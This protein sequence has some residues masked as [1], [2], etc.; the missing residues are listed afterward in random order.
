MNPVVT[1]K[2]HFGVY[3]IILKNNAILLVRKS[4]GPYTGKLDLP[5]GRPE[6]AELPGKTAAREVLEETGIVIHKALLFE[7][8]AVI[9]QQS[10]AQENKQENMHHMGVVYLAIDYDDTNLIKEMDVEDSL[11]AQWYSLDSLTQKDCSPFAWY[12][13][14]D[15]KKLNV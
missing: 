2:S 8:Y 5:G 11:G 9:A 10:I 7:H 13:V 6:H 14:R 1:N 4:R 15:T 12:A 3:V